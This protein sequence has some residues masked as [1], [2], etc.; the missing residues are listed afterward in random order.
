[1]RTVTVDVI[2]EII[3]GETK[4]LQVMQI[5]AAFLFNKLLSVAFA[6][7]KLWS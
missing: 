2:A 6:W 5:G 3:G 1:M 4:L 7:H